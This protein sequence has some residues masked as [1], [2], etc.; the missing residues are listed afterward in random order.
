LERYQSTK[1]GKQHLDNLGLHYV[2]QA[3]DDLRSPSL[4]KLYEALLPRPDGVPVWGDKSHHRIFCAEDFFS[5][6]PHS[7]FVIITRDPRAAI[8]SKFL[9]LIA[10]REGQSVS[11]YDETIASYDNDWRL[12]A[13]LAHQW[14]RWHTKAATATE[15][16]PSDHQITVKYE[17]LVLHPR[18]TIN[19]V[20]EAVGVE[21]EGNMLDHTRWKSIPVMKSPSSY[22][23]IRLTQPLDPSRITAWKELDPKLIWVIERVARERMRL[24]G[25]DL[26]DPSV[27][28]L[29]RWHFAMMEIADKVRAWGQCSKGWM[30]ALS[31]HLQL[32]HL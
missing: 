28:S 17:D 18:R 12:F 24:L 23:H 9:K 11:A 31:G 16:I 25:Y 5:L 14:S 20:C 21:F 3:I 4:H 32:I 2:R 26:K 6:Y 30:K 22:A 13:Q 10:E 8:A 27:D 15:S 29:T 19:R 7:L 1:G